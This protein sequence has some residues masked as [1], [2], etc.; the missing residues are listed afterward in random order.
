M[1][2]HF[3]IEDAGFD[4]NFVL[5]W[6]SGA[7]EVRPEGADESRCTNTTEDVTTTAICE[8]VVVLSP[9]IVERGNVWT[10]T[11]SNVKKTC[12]S[13]NIVVEHTHR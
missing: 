3:V 4:A 11:V 10:G 9:A 13:G 7:G 6:E 2:L 1:V 12:K 5:S 8:T